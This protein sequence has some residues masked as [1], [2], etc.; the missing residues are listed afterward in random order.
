M[1]AE[2]DYLVRSVFPEI[3]T[4][5]RA[6][7]VQFTDI[8]LRWG[9]TREEA[10][11]GK[12]LAICLDE[13][14][15][16]RPYF[17]GFLG[18]RYGW[19]PTDSDLTR[20]NELIARFPS[21][22]NSLLQHLSVTE[23]EIR[24][25]VFDTSE[26]A[27]H[28]FFYFRSIELS[29]QLMEKCRSPQSDYFESDKCCRSKLARLKKNIRNSGLPLLDGYTSI[30]EFGNRVKD[31]LLKVLEIR[32]PLEFAPTPL[33]IQRSSHEAYGESRCH[34]YVPDPETIDALN[35]WVL[36]QKN[37]SPLVIT[38]SSGLGKSSLIAYWTSQQKLSISQHIISHYVGSAGDSTP[39]HIIGRL[40]EEIRHIFSIE[41]P[42]P[43]DSDR[44]LTQFSEWLARIPATEKLIIVLDG[45][46][47][48]DVDH[49]AWLPI[50]WPANVRFVLT[51][52]PGRLLDQC[53]KQRAKLTRFLG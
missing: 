35:I 50:F 26:M 43:E 48:I 42:L 5:C 8:D 51:V 19:S 40:I 44:I 10:E 4:A 2:R 9:L 41:H 16:C 17:I 47:Q 18:E 37:L 45:L 36:N 29:E 20:K 53:V 21:V 22:E 46:N 31:D 23:M 3:R 6:R 25:G 52:T 13:I 27:T 28:S 34:A 12:V 14:E 24:H 32:F 15:K 33:E 7:H 39:F 38:G 1:Q 49:L 11:Q 30:Q